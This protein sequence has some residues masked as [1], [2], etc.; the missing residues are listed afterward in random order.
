MGTCAR[1]RLREAVA[2]RRTVSNVGTWN[3][4]EPVC[5]HCRDELDEL[6]ERCNRAAIGVDRMIRR[7]ERRVVA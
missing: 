5:G 1:C 6:S 4:S 2:Y 7:R 3:A